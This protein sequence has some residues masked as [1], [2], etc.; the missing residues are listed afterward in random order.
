MREDAGSFRDPRYQCDEEEL[1]MHQLNIQVREVFANRF[2]QMFA[3]YEVFVI[4]PSHDK[5]SWFTNRDQMQ[6]FDKVNSKTNKVFIFS[7]PPLSTSPPPSAR[8]QAS[9]LSDQPEPYLPFLSRFLET[10]M[11]ASF[12][13]SKILCHDDEEKEH[14]LRVFDSRVDKIRML[15]VRTPTLRTSM[16]QKCTNIEEAGEKPWKFFPEEVASY[17][18]HHGAFI[19][20]FCQA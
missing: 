4:Q 18:E 9:F 17:P 8:V 7:D 11:F 3:D 20:D 16:Y 14:T 12:I 5:E 6:N 19:F 15:N 10:Q 13:D 1:K 2:T